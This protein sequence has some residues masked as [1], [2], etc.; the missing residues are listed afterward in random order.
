ME[1]HDR[2]AGSIWFDHTCCPCTVTCNCQVEGN[3]A[4]IYKHLK[5]CYPIYCQEQEF[6]SYNEFQNLAVYTPITPSPL[7]LKINESILQIGRKEETRK[8]LEKRERDI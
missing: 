8:S 5:E 3:I 6:S 1:S 2:A 4:E 7:I